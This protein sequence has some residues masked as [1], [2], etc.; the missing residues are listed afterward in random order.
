MQ[1]IGTKISFKSVIDNDMN[2]VEHG[3]ARKS[4]EQVIENLESLPLN[5]LGDEQLAKLL[6]FH[7]SVLRD[8]ATTLETSKELRV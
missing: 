8:I 5:S 2:K 1:G 3:R 7:A 6:K 4:V